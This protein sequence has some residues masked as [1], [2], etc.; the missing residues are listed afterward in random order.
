M[1]AGNKSGSRTQIIT[2]YKHRIPIESTYSSTKDGPTYSAGS[3]GIPAKVIVTIPADR[4][5]DTLRD[6]IV[7]GMGGKVVEE[8]E[9]KQGMLSGKDYQIEGKRRAHMQMYMQGGFVFLAI[10]EAKTKAGISTKTADAFFESFIM[11][12]EAAEGK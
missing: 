8:K 6:S 1:P 12:P 11:T 9:L 3:I 10:V 5:F 2:I 4:R 7:K